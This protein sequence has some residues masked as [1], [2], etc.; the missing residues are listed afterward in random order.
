MNFRFA[1]RSI[2]I[3]A[4]SILAVATAEAQSTPKMLA[5]NTLPGRVVDVKAGEFFFKAL[6]TI[7]AGLTT[8][9]LEQVGFVVDRIRA[10]V[11]GRA[12]VT[13]KGDATRGAHMLWIV[14]LED[15]KTVAD[16]YRAEQARE[17]TPW[18]QD[19]GGPGYIDP[20][21]TTNATIE[22]QPGNYALVCHMGGARED[23]TR[24]HL[25]NG[26][27]RPFT[28]VAAKGKR[29][30]AP[31]PDVRARITGDGVVEFS[32]PIVAGRQ[33]VQVENTTAKSHE[34]KFHKVPAGMTAAQVF[35]GKPGDDNGSPAGGLAHVPAGGIVTTTL[36]FEPGEHTI[37]TQTSMRHPTS[38]AFVVARRR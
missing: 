22:L 28:V 26:M 13:D 33:V 16:L 32:T 27:V 1:C 21:R 11:K 14:K 5:D 37:A 24:S 19:L 4:L 34:F 25:L 12:R 10:G 35:A 18:A 23:R 9:R 30:I 3:P 29:S 2:G 31:K 15:G 38:R 6:D 17:A 7:P 20:P 36:Y 8:F